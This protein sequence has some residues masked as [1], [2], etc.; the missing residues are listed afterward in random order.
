[1]LDN[2][3]NAMFSNVGGKL[4]LIAKITFYVTVIPFAVMTI[5][6]FIAGLVLRDLLVVFMSLFYLPLGIFLG[7]IS[8]VSTYAYGE[9][10]DK[11]RDIEKN[12][13]KSIEEI[14][15]ITK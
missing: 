10:V 8:A 5:G 6:M 2:L 1:M 12:T 7:W 11:V 3:F 4:K 15:S 13:N 14:D 9:L